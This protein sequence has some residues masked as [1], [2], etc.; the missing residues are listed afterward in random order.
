MT[1]KSFFN[2][3][4]FVSELSKS[5]ISPG[6]DM[7]LVNVPIVRLGKLSAMRNRP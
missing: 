4:Y 6:V 3:S 1:K 5:S 2:K 7:I